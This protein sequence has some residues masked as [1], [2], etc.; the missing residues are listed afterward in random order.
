LKKYNLVEAVK[1][2]FEVLDQQ[3]E[4]SVAIKEKIK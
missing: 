2:T 1:E 4:K 3:P